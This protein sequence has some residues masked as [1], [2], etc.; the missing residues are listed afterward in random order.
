LEWEN[1]TASPIWDSD[2]GFG[3]N[4]VPE[5]SDRAVLDG[6]CVIDGPFQHYEIPY[7]DEIYRPHCLSRGFLE[8]DELKAQ[9]EQ[10]HPDK[11]ES[12]LDV[13][14]YESFNLGLENGPHLAIPRSIRGDFSLLTAPSGT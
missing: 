5:R 7:L 1:V 12:L 2:H 13:E 3:S 10:L 4:G 8:G 9:A 6:Y 11:I 14:D